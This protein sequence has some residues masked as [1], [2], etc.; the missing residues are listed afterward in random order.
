MNIRQPVFVGI[1]VGTSGVRGVCVDIHLQ[2][3]GSA[4]VHFD[5]ASDDRRNPQ[6]WWQSVVQVIRQ[7]SGQLDPARIVSIAIDG[8]SGTMVAVDEAGVPQGDALLY[9]D[10]CH[11]QQVLDSIAAHAPDTSAAHGATS[12]L[13]RAIGLSARHNGASILHEADW[14][15]FQLSGI[16]GLSDENNALKTGYDPLLRQW[17]EWIEYTGITRSRLPHVVAAGHPLGAISKQAQLSTGLHAHTQVVAGTTDGCASFLATGAASPGDGVTILG[18]TL[19]IKLLSDKPIYAPEYGIYSHRIGN[20]WLAGGASNTGGKVLAAYFTPDEIQSLSKAIDTT[21]P[22]K[23]NYYPLI[24]PGERF[25][26]NDSTL[27]PCL[28]PRPEDDAVFLHGMLD[29]IAQI[30]SLAYERLQELGAPLLSSIRTMG[31]GAHNPAW[32]DMR[33]QKL[34]VNFLVSISDQAAVGSASLARDGYMKYQNKLTT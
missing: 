31:G 3:L 12:G 17:P 4:F 23:L 21:V 30:E 32:T 7:L 2:T 19:T 5:G 11:D 13:A 20:R 14:I 9:N 29:G 25:P 18:S 22:C 6:L 24:S 10:P 28:E 15:A 26:I 1:D 33:K 16:C 8:T 34:G 27:Q